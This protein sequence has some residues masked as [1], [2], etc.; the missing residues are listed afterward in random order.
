MSFPLINISS[1]KSRHSRIEPIKE[2]ACTIKRHWDGVLNWFKS[3]ISNGILVGSTDRLLKPIG[4]GGKVLY[5][6]LLLTFM[7]ACM[8]S[9]C[10]GAPGPVILTDDLDELP[11]GYHLEYLEDPA[12]ALTIADVAS[13]EYDGRFQPGSEKTLNLGYS[14]S[15]YWVRFRAVNQA[16]PQTQ[17][18]LLISFPYHSDIRLYSPKDDNSG[19]LEKRSGNLVPITQREVPQPFYAFNL[20]LPSGSRQLF[21]LRFKSQGQ[22]VLPL[23]ILSPKAFLTLEYRT[24]VFQGM[25]YGILLIMAAYNLVLFLMLRE[26]SYAYLVFF[27]GSILLMQSLYDGYAQLLLPSIHTWL[28]SHGTVIAF[29]LIGVSELLFVCAYL[30]TRERTPKLHLWLL[31][32]TALSAA[33]VVLAAILPYQT[34]I[35]MTF[36]LRQAII[37]TLLFVGILLSLKRYRP[38]Y[39][40][41]SAWILVM[42]GVTLMSCVRAG[43]LE[44]HPFIERA[45]QFGMIAAVLLLSLGLA[46]RITLLKQEREAAREKALQISLDNERFMR[47]Q[48]VLLEQRISE[49]TAELVTTRDAAEAAN[50]AKSDFVANMSHEI[51]TPMNAILGLIHLAMRRD[52][53]AT[54]RNY[55]VRIGEAANSLLGIITNVLDFSRIESVSLKLESVVFRLD[56]VLEEVSGISAVQSR[57]KDIPLTFTVAP[58]VPGT[59]KGD[60]LRLK[61]VLLNLVG[62][63][64]KFTEAGR[65]DVSV[66][67]GE[68]PDFETG[69]IRLCFAVRD[70]GVGIE[71]E[72]IGRLFEPFVQ[73]DVST[74]RK[75]GGSGLGLTICRQLVTLMGGEIRIQ[76]RPGEGSVFSFTALF[77]PSVGTESAVDRQPALSATLEPN[78]ARA[79]LGG[80]RVLLVDDNAVNRMIAGELLEDAG[81]AV[82]VAVSGK[83]AVEKVKRAAYDLVLMDIQMSEMDGYETTRQIRELDSAVPI[84]ALTAKA[85]A[86]ERE[87]CLDA[88]MN[89]Y[90]GKPFDPKDLYRVAAHWVVSPGGDL[91]AETVGSFPGVFPPRPLPDVDG[92]DAALG[93]Q[94]TNGNLGLYLRVL[95]AFASSHA[96]VCRKI[97]ARVREEGFEDAARTA[98]ALKGAAGSIGATALHELGAALESA[99]DNKDSNR[100]P[101]LLT[102]LEGEMDRVLA[103]VEVL[104]E[105]KPLSEAPAAEQPA[106]PGPAEIERLLDELAGALRRS[107]TQAGARLQA[108]QRTLGDGPWTARMMLI[109]RH[110][111]NFDFDDALRELG[112]MMN[113]ECGMMNEGEWDG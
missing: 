46:D 38:A 94:R 99:L 35:K 68:S 85:M 36:L 20:P 5:S 49:R 61:Q 56:R 21:Y 13:P 63:A 47:E 34:T 101:F 2:A 52:P 109:E 79:H 102:R 110:I 96:E 87:R 48:K 45:Y 66:T 15:V 107:S 83:Q 98:H 74:T 80:A 50:R 71:E 4:Q 6:V 10:L 31:A 39:Y 26:K 18:R 25:Y 78:G 105:M 19:L 33:G 62:N 55:L 1:L 24:G 73:A 16:A 54:Q 82:D 12:G 77:E 42:A 91:P 106:T 51:R 67:L 104:C 44:Y 108:L 84:V 111:A 72:Q 28:I 95:A 60:P 23:T 113:D 69:P 100:V 64:L 29:N 43:L 76:S 97:E 17:W 81:M 90:L 32:L 3:G 59:L 40:F 112:E 30:A 58:E 11:L 89:D 103:A 14:R 22:M 65:V 57:E 75:Y 53:P 41:L 9:V 7:L 92:I 93:L 86:G 8:H 88:G 37:W 70:T 27:L